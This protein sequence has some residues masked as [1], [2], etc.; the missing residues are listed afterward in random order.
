MCVCVCVS[1]IALKKVSLLKYLSLLIT[2]VS[3]VISKAEK[4]LK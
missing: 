3:S 4:H 2:L 1:V